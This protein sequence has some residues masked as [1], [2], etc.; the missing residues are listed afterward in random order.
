MRYHYLF[1]L[2]L[3]CFLSANVSGCSSSEIGES[4][5]VAQETIFQQYTISYNEGEDS[6]VVNA[7]FRFSGENGT[8]LVL[9]QPS[10]LQLDGIPF[11]VDSSDFSGAFYKKSMPA[12]YFHT[13]HQLT[14]TDIN[15]KEYKNSFSFDT[16]KLVNIPQKADKNQAIHI[17]FEPANIGP[18]DYIE[19][20]A[21]DT[22]STFSVTYSGKDPGRIITIPA[23]ELA[24]QKAG[25][26]KLAAK[27]YKKVFLQ[28][29][30]KEGGIL[31]IEYALK[32]FII[33]IR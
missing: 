1:R 24:R 10:S 12:R 19:I 23:E 29:G 16:F 31:E 21:L 25:Q 5:D 20:G 9:T 22:D 18:D 3:F 4:K 8:T 30:T 7:I 6:A 14:F 11:S 13:N 15:N 27:Y 17:Q 26:L 28:Q 2:A 32:P 33:E